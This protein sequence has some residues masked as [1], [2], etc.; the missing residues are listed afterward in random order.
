MYSRITAI[1]ITIFKMKKYQNS[2]GDHRIKMQESLPKNLRL[3]I[4]DFTM[5]SVI[6]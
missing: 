1:R 2:P 4:Q 6:V 5:K 3:L